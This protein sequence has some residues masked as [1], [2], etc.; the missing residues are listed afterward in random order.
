MGGQGPP[1]GNLGFP[2]GFVGWW[3][4]GGNGCECRNGW[5]GGMVRNGG[6]AGGAGGSVKFIFSNFNYL[7]RK[8]IMLCGIGGGGAL[9]YRIGWVG[10]GCDC[11]CV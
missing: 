8:P 10:R 7:H 2:N 3:V 9:G 5:L 4:G 6:W 11:L 1:E